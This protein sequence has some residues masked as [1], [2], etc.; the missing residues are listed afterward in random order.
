[1][2]RLNG[3]ELKDVWQTPEEITL[4]LPHI[5]LDPCAGD[6]T[7]IGDVDWNERGL[8]RE[9]FGNVFV[10]PPFSQKNVWLE[11]AT[12]QIKRD[13]V[14]TIFV[15]TPDSTDVKSWWHTHT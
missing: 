14:D 2:T 7:N 12:D 8:Q 5:D 6:D 15:L 9:W 4:L 10:N 1:M 13:D 11:Y 3:A